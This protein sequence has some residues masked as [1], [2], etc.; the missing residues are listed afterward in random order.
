MEPDLWKI[1]VPAEG[2]EVH[3]DVTLAPVFGRDAAGFQ[4]GYGGGYFACILTALSGPP[5]QEQ[6]RC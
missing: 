6:R 1:P 5:E 3:P 4:L 2:P